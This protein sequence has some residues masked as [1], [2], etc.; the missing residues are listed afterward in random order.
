M[1]SIDSQFMIML[2]FLLAMTM[3]F[4]ILLCIVFKIVCKKDHVAPEN[5][6]IAMRELQ[7]Q[8]GDAG[9]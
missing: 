5:N 1:P 3:M 7:L 8:N 2:L 9:L 6:D 4:F